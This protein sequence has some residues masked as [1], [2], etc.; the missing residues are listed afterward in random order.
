MASPRRKPVMAA[1]ITP[2]QTPARS[3]YRATP[4]STPSSRST[5]PVLPPATP[6]PIHPSDQYPSGK[7][8]S[9]AATAFALKAY[10]ETFLH[11]IGW[12]P[13]TTDVTD[14]IK[15][16]SWLLSEELNTTP[17]RAAA[18]F[19]EIFDK[20]TPDM[21]AVCHALIGMEEKLHCSRETSKALRHLF[22]RN[23]ETTPETMLE[24]AGEQLEEK[25][26]TMTLTGRKGLGGGFAIWGR[27]FGGLFRQMF[28]KKKGKEWEEEEEVGV[29]GKK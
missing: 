29:V 10:L 16:Y 14:F 12:D 15:Q 2:V 20:T 4:F 7:I 23:H 11:R 9:T 28:G 8:L 13:A 21:R 18:I 17:D 26:G 1:V 6:L 25:V 22:K 27:I 5:V 24:I 19:L 3:T